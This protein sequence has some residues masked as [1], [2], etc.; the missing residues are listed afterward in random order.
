MARRGGGGSGCDEGSGG[1][2]CGVLG[3]R[4]IAS[5]EDTA[6]SA[7]LIGKHQRRVGA[8]GGEVV[9]KIA[10]V[11]D[12]QDRPTEAEA[13]ADV[14]RDVILDERVVEQ[15]GVRHAK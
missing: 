1:G 12:A 3:S 4:V 15:V 6:G 9:R 5:A 7:R 13:D 11:A 14:G 10:V 2:G 8:V